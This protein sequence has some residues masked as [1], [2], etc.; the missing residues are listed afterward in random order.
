MVLF[1][2]NTSRVADEPYPELLRE[3][4]GTGFPTLVFMDET[5]EVLT[6]QGDRTVA[7]FQKT[8]D[9]LNALQSARKKAAS[10]DPKAKKEVFL[11]ELDLGKLKAEDA[12]AQAK[13]LEFTADERKKIDTT[14]FGLE[15]KEILD[16]VRGRPEEVPALR[17]AAVEKLLPL[18]ERAGSLT[19]PIGMRYWAM[20]GAHAKEQGD[21]KLEAECKERLER[22]REPPKKK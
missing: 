22:L 5:G 20:L 11:A 1:L 18:K 7:G 14:I 8:L 4:G 2:H 9:S 16:T 6:R 17:A 19:G 13:G 12:K 3:K 15:V 10:G 21:E